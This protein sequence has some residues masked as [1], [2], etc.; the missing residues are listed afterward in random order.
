MKKL[1]TSTMEILLKKA[2][3]ERVSESAKE[4]IL[5]ILLKKIEKTSAKSQEF[6]EHANRKTIKKKDIEMS[7]NL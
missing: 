7:L 1:P 6:A 4:E 5:N 3:A 2:G